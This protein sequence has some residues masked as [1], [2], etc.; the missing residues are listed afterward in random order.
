M[1]NP[2]ADPLELT[3][4]A[5]GVVRSSRLTEAGVSW[6]TVAAAI[7][8]GDL[9]RVRRRWLALPDADPSLV[10]AARGGVIMTCVTAAVHHGLWVP[11]HDEAHVAAAPHAG[12]VD[13]VAGTRVHRSRPLVPRHPDA[14]VDGVVNTLIVVATCLAHEPALVIWESALNKGLVSL[15]ELTGLPLPGKARAL[16]QIAQPLADSGLE[17]FVLVRLRWLGLRLVP[18]AFLFGHRVDR[19]IG[20]RL[21]LQIDGAHHVGAQRD[22]DIRHDAVLMVNGYHVI[23]VGYRQVVHDWP[24]VQSLITRAIARGLHRS[25]EGGAS[26]R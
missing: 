2:R 22:A 13:V 14:L 5:G 20:D 7:E 15:D 16:A 23:R 17:T 26:R 12:R 1:P 18:Q 11:S 10:A 6:R 21:V 25:G 3:R 4:R 24:G 9:I 19:L 8:C